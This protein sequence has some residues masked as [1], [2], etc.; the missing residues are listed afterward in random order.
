MKRKVISST[1]LLI[2]VLSMI[3]SLSAISSGIGVAKADSV[4]ATISVGSHPL[5]SAFNPDN[6][7]MYVTN[8]GSHTVSII[9]GKTNTVVGNPIPVGAFTSRISFDPV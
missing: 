5:T 2:L 4:I 7:D 8:Q 3:L 9:D 6:G 1:S